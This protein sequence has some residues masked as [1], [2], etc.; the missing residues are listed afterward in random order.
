MKILITGGA[1]FIG[2]HLAAHLHEQ[3][4]EVTILDRKQKRKLVPYPYIQADCRDAIDM[5]QIIPSFDIVYHLAAH[6][7][8]QESINSPRKYWENNVGGTKIV[9][10]TKKK[11]TKL[12][13]ASSAG[14]HDVLNPYALTKKISEKHVLEEDGYI[15]RFYNV[16]GPDQQGG[17][18][19]TWIRQALLNLPITI[20]GTGEQCRDYVYVEDLVR[21]IKFDQAITEYGDGRSCNLIRLASIIRQLCNSNSEVR[22]SPGYDGDVMS[23]R[24]PTQNFETQYGFMKGLEKTVAY[25]AE[26]L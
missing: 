18:I 10:G 11:D 17:V 22:H 21:N 8:A 26:T 12:F 23:S 4:K 19:I 7:N 1:G 14:V 25:I 16:F 6:I 9:L 15:G 13:F 2:S 20:Y 24:A 5:N 3:G